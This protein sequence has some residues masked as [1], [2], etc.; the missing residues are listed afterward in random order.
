MS[1]RMLLAELPRPDVVV[2]NADEIVAPSDAGWA[3]AALAAR[4]RHLRPRI[5]LVPFDRR[6][7]FAAVAPTVGGGR[8]QERC[9][10]D[11]IPQLR[12]LV[13]AGGAQGVRVLPQVWSSAVFQLIDALRS[14]GVELAV[15][16]I[17][18]VSAS[19]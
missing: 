19:Q 14:A 2:A 8:E 18:Q 1:R 4:A 3:G 16:W 5:C 9:L 11:R 6:S 13:R 15:D 12:P 7:D 17:P 10:E